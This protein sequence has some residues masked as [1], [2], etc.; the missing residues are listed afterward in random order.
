MC[1]ALGIQTSLWMGCPIRNL[2]VHGLD[3]APPKRFAGLRVLHRFHAP[4][5]PPRTLCSLFSTSIMSC[6][7]GISSWYFVLPL[8]LLDTRQMLLTSALSKIEETILYSVVKE[9]FCSSR[10]S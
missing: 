3:A 7:C 6:L 8:S 10:C 1:S 2:G 4:R 9:L 5:H